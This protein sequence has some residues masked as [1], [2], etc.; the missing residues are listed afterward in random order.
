MLSPFVGSFLF[1][2]VGIIVLKTGAY[3]PSGRSVLFAVI[4]VVNLLHWIDHLTRVGR[5]GET[6]SRI[7][8]AARQAIG[9]RLKTD[10]VC[11]AADAVSD[12]VAQA[13]ARP[14]TGGGEESAAA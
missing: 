11:S 9:H 8:G 7:E 1:S 12:A 10:P 2:I 5:V 6:T 14:V 3:G 4:I 13:L